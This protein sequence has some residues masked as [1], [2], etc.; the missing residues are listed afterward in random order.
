MAKLRIKKF[1]KIN[2]SIQLLIVLCFALTGGKYLN[3]TLKSGF[4]AVSL[5]LEEI[6]M[7]I[8]PGIIFTFLF[9]CLLSLKN[10]ILTLVSFL[11][12]AICVS[13]FA[14]AILAYIFGLFTLPRMN[15]TF[16]AIEQVSVKLSPLWKIELPPIINS[17]YALL[18]A[19][20]LGI[21]FSIH[22]SSQIEYVAHK[23]KEKLNIFLEKGFTPLLPL[24]T[25][26]FV[27][28]MQHEGALNLIIQGYG[29][30]LALIV[31]LYLI[32]LATLYCIVAK[33]D[34][35][36]AYFY[37]KNVLPSGIMGFT[38]ISSI[39]T[40]PITLRS[41]EK[42]TKNSTI[43]ETVIPFTVNMHLIGDSLAIPVMALAILLSF[44]Q[45]LPLF[46]QYLLFAGYFMLCRLAVAAVPGGGILIMLPIL[47]GYL[48]FSPEMSALITTLFVLF[49]P[50]AT[51]VNV[52]GNGGFAILANQ[53]LKARY[54]NTLP[55]SSS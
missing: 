27:L 21:I 13:N 11:L 48:G 1:F 14:S 35:K 3:V 46:G 15:L 5:M 42:N 6:L 47:E 26:G 9:S 23:L 30:I 25:L 24:F 53:C 2:L 17:E 31:A 54:I 19:L 55:T 8:M 45:P 38:T 44:G 34:L 10:K 4:Y 29:P 39:A 51:A 16:Q 49:D 20:G 52:I 18:L 7:F 28:K 36:Q 41:A 33:F 40:M 50:F 43:V 12:I 32:Y 22:P 37:L